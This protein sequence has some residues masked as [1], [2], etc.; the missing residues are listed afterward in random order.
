V[1]DQQLSATQAYG[2]IPQADFERREGRQVVHA[3]LHLDK[4][5]HVEVDDFVISMR[6]FQGGLE[7]AWETGCIRSSYVVLRP[8]AS[9]HPAFFGHLFKSTAY[10][11]ALQATSNF[12]RDGQ[13][14]NWGYFTQVDLPLVPL[15]TQKA[16]AAFLD[17]KTAAI[18]ALIEKKQKLLE[19]L[20]EKRAAL[21]DRLLNPLDAP[22]VRLAMTVDLLPGHAFSSSDF[23]RGDEGV[24]L[25]RG[26]NVCPGY[27]RWEDTVRWPSEAVVV[28]RR[29]FLR[30]GDIVL[31]M[32]RPWIGGGLRAATIEPKDCPCL[33]L[34][35]VARLR[36]RAA[37]RSSY[38]RL[39]LEWKRFRAHLEPELTGV[40]VPHLSGDQILSYRIPT[41][42][43][44]VQDMIVDR[45][46]M[47][48]AKDEIA[49][50]AMTKQV[51]RLQEYRQALIT[52]A[53][54]GQ[55]EIN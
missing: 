54:T 17:R 55:I 31:G 47:H 1:G 12:I 23:L 15:A 20:A 41:P 2:V 50:V 25:L 29:F 46:T 48:H 52:A 8:S 44:S 21:I 36:A 34:Q 7:R 24:P 38:L 45:A 11:Q 3:F 4:R 6:S 13:D 30:P 10:I 51:E 27:L 32:D 39:A 49:R 9:A 43:L 19:L 53:V 18:D 35:R 5:K 40:S 16:I 26:I 14:L 33:L 28:G 37:L 22:R 42:T